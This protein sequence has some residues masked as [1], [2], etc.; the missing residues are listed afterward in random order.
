MLISMSMGPLVII[1]IGM[2]FSRS[3]LNLNIRYIYDTLHNLISSSE[4]DPVSRNA[5]KKYR[6]IIEVL[7]QKLLEK[8]ARI[9]E[10]ESELETANK[11]KNKFKEL[12]S[13]LNAKL[14]EQKSTI[15]YLEKQISYLKNL[16]ESDIDSICSSESYDPSK[17]EKLIVLLKGE[18]EKRRKTESFI[19]ELQEIIVL[20]ECDTCDESTSES[21]HHHSHSNLDTYLQ[22]IRERS[23]ER[24]VGKEC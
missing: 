21:T 2:I 20:D 15:H 5:P 22:L 17:V 14:K 13:K 6:S 16:R 7:K 23:E 3:G 1:I 10:L 8:A 24:R 11:K 9:E 19:S 12:V 18:I 4:S